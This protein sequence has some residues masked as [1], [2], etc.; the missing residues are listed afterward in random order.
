MLSCV[1]GAC[2]TTSRMQ[3]TIIPRLL[4]AELRT[5][6][7]QTPTE[8][9]RVRECLMGARMKSAVRNVVYDGRTAAAAAAAQL[10]VIKTRGKALAAPPGAVHLW[11]VNTT[12][13]RGQH[14]EIGQGAETKMRVQ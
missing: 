6:I 7:S 13:H 11:P 14:G 4:L 10:F 5:A 8:R 3:E 9:N 12:S 1:F 2:M